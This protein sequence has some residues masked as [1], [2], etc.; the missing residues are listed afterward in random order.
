MNEPEALPAAPLPLVQLT[1]LEARVLGCLIEKAATTPEVYPLTLNAAHL[2]CNQKSNRDPIMSAELGAVGQALRALED[3]GL[4]RVVHGARALRYEHAIDAA[5]N[6]TAR[7]RA[8]IALL[9]L[10]GPQTQNELL[11][12]SERL[13]DFPDSAILGD[14]L[15]RLMAR[16]PPLVV[17]IGRAPGQRED[18]FMHLLCGPVS[19]EDLPAPR[20]R[21]SESPDRHAELEARIDALERE[22]AELRE[23]IGSG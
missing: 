19:I 4:V 13:A 20:T 17:R 21:T 18:R 11:T 22:V 12:R 14:T 7:A 3:K 15:E 9:L 23:K 16:E 1:A 10:R 5:L 8:V 2:A 6:L